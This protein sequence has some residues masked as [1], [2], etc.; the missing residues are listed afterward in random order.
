M[1]NIV[2]GN[3]NIEDAKFIYELK[4]E[5]KALEYSFNQ[6]KYTFDEF[7]DI[8]KE[9]YFSNDVPPYIVCLEKEK[10]AFIGLLKCDN[11]YTIGI[12]LHKN[13]RGKGLGKNILNLFINKI[14]E[15]KFKC[16]IIAKIKHFNIP[17][18]KTF[19]NIGFK[20]IMDETI[21]NQQVKV[22]E[23]LI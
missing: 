17:S 23:Y 2:E 8:Y 5:E 6:N 4:Y 18:I 21:N 15:Y 9:K 13:Y 12:N 14:K 19:E 22:F 11:Y 7:F 10:I 3:K 16:K 1:L 20:Y